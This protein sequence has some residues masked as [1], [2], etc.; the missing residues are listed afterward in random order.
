ME[1]WPWK[2]KVDSVSLTKFITTWTA[3]TRRKKNSRRGSRERSLDYSQEVAVVQQPVRVD[4]ARWIDHHSSIM[5]WIRV[6]GT[7]NSI[8]STITIKSWMISKNL[9]CPSSHPTI[10]TEVRD[11]HQWLIQ[12]S[13]HRTRLNYQ[14][15][16]RK[17]FKE[18]NLK[19]QIDHPWGLWD[20][21][22]Q[23]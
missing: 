9:I 3:R 2:T 14:P 5:R 15:R 17:W 7:T 13:H 11:Q 21:Q 4:W 16:Q 6:R 22:R 20:P 10:A 18:V 12:G 1:E 8:R 19:W 23:L